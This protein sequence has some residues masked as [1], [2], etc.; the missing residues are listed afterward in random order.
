MSPQQVRLDL[1]EIAYVAA[2]HHFGHVRIG[3]LAERPFASVAEMDAELVARW[4]DVVGADDVVL[5]L[6]DLALGDLETTRRPPFSAPRLRALGLAEE[7]TASRPRRPAAGGTTPTGL[8]ALRTARLLG[9]SG[10]GRWSRAAKPFH[11]RDCRVRFG[12]ERERLDKEIELIRAAL[13]EA[14]TT[15]PKGRTLQ[16]EL[17]RRR[18]AVSWYST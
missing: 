12:R 14:P 1:D 13:E 2:D 18:W 8:H 3:E 7:R 11:S 16:A 5:H 4:N 6:G 10:V 9:A 17:A 15:T